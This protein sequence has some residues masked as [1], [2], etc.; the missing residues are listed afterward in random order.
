MVGKFC[1]L[2]DVAFNA[3]DE[4]FELRQDFVHIRGDFRHGPRKNIEIIVA[5]HF[6]FAEF[7]PERSITRSCVGKRVP[8]C[9]R[10]PW[11][12]LPRGTDAIKLVLLLE[13]S[14]FSLQPFFRET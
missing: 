12:C 11:T 8:R 10:T 7:R 6:K 9:R 3:P 4:T 13:L 5:V 14:D 2:V 1:E